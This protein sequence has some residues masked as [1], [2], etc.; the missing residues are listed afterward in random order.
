MGVGKW[1]VE[2][3]M[4]EKFFNERKIAKQTSIDKDI[5]VSMMWRRKKDHIDDVR[6]LPVE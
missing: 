2:I 3:S 4:A 5:P 1:D 6:Y